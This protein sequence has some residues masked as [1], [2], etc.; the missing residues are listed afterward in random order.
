MQAEADADAE[1]NAEADA[2][3]DAEANADAEALR[4]SSSREDKETASGENE[5]RS[6]DDDDP[7]DHVGEALPENGA[8]GERKFW[9]ILQFEV[10]SKAMIESG[11]LCWTWNARGESVGEFS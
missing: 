4:S 3:A 5:Q 11:W 8:V 1:A 9:E 10:S 2:E 7:A 6:N